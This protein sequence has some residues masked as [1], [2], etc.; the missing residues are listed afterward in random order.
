MATVQRKTSGRATSNN[1]REHFDNVMINGYTRKRGGSLKR[2]DIPD[3]DFSSHFSLVSLLTLVG[4]GLRFA[5]RSSRWIGL[6]DL[7]PIYPFVGLAYLDGRMD[8]WIGNLFGRNENR[9]IGTDR[10]SWKLDRN[11]CLKGGMVLYLNR[12]GR[13]LTRS[14]S[15]ID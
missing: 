15:R 9:W 10:R 4:C 1:T 7:R 11:L 5:H 14:Q 3:L 2:L 12:P 13:V 8:G 6:I